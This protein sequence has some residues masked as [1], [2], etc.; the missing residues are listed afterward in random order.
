MLTPSAPSCLALLAGI[1]APGALDAGAFAC[2]FD[3][4]CI[5]GS[6]C[7]D[8]DRDARLEARTP[9]AAVLHLET[10]SLGGDL[11]ALGLT[12]LFDGAAEGLRLLLGIAADGRARL[13]AM[14]TDPLRIAVYLGSCE[15]L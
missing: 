4:V 7:V 15:E 8:T 12:R 11:R 2:R 6:M 3:V 1:A 9:P 13:M 5:E 10:G 14:E